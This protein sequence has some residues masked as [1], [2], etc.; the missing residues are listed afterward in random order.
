[1]IWFINVA[2]PECHNGGGDDGNTCVA[3]FANDMSV[4]SE[5]RLHRLV[6]TIKLNHHQV[7]RYLILRFYAVHY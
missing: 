5:R 6:W 2:A 3:S 7:R 4:M 1:M